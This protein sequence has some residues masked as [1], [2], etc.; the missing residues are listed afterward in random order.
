M[1]ENDE[2]GTMKRLHDDLFFISTYK[3]NAHTL[4]ELQSKGITVT[5]AGFP[6]ETVVHINDKDKKYTYLYADRKDAI[7]AFKYENILPK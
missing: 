2:I 4:Q 1:D 6:L 7:G 5:S 3:L